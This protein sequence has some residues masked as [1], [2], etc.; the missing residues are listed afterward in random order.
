MRKPS[1]LYFDLGNVLLMFDHHRGAAQMA[2]VA[3]IPVE[4]VWELVFQG[5]LQKRVECGAI[6]SQEFFDEFCQQTNSQPDR[7]ELALAASAI[8]EINASIV[9]L[10]ATL[11][12]SN[13][14]MG[15]LSNTCED[16]WN[17]VI[18]NRYA[19]IPSLFEVHVLSHEVGAA[20]PDAKIYEVA[21][22]RAGC[23]ANEVFFVDDLAGHV[24]GA[25][26][27]GFD[28]VQFESVDR[29]AMDLRQRGLEF[30]F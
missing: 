26:A 7:D 1:F 24:A 9:P 2:E 19:I 28:A 10:V 14:R 25:R 22:D 3:G 8:F 23:P 16:H 4:Q 6:S 15:V 27:A 21:A 11:H 5:D 12:V 18:N 20:K 30:N 17:Y 13:H 29:L